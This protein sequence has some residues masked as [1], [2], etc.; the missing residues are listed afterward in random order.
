MSRYN[1]TGWNFDNSY[2]Q[3]PNLFYTSISPTPVHSPKLVILNEQLA[4][5]LGLNVGALQSGEG[6][7]V[8]AGNSIPAG[9]EPLAQAYAGH[10]FGHF[11]M[12]GD[13]R[14][15]LLGEQITPQGDRMD[16]QL[17]GSGKTPYSRGGM[18]GRRWDRCCASILSARR[19]MRLVFLQPAVWLL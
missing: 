8:F 4:E 5:S 18:A 1:Q 3:L 12:L 14:A 17:K 15:V 9:A 6:A 19:C 13:G 7:A 10:Q 16:I 2:A 11:T